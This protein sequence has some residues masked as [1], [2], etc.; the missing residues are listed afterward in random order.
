MLKTLARSRSSS[1]VSRSNSNVASP[2]P[3]KHLGDVA[4]AGAVAAAAAAV[5]EHDDPGRVLRDREV[6]GHRHRPGGHPDFLVAQ[7]RVSTLA[8][9][10]DFR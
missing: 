3:F 2:A 7:R 4:V 6:P 8:L 10:D 1:G 5:G 9:A